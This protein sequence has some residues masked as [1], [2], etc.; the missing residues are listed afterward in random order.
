M[1]SVLNSSVCLWNSQCKCVCIQ[2]NLTQSWQPIVSLTTSVFNGRRVWV[3]FLLPFLFIPSYPVL[4]SPPSFSC[5]FLCSPLGWS[6]LAGPGGSQAELEVSVG[7]LTSLCLSSSA[8]QC[9][10]MA[11]WKAQR[12]QQWRSDDPTADA[13]FR[14]S[15]ALR[16]RQAADPAFLHCSPPGGQE[17][18]AVVRPQAFGHLSSPLKNRNTGYEMLSG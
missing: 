8:V 5:L 15:Q 9:R 3:A 17:G 13:H 12:Q 16:L 11:Y 18:T 6:H 1:F 2:Y 10:T 7:G 14:H 4:L